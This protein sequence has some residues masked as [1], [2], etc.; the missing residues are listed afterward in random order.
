M[1][2]KDII[3]NLKDIEDVKS[4]NVANLLCNCQTFMR[5]SRGVYTIRNEQK[6]EIKA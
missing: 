3:K 5:L 6:I 1:K 4:M 2:A